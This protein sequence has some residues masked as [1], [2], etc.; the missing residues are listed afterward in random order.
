MKKIFRNLMTGLA[1]TAAAACASDEEEISSILPKEKPA[2]QTVA[3]ECNI[4]SFGTALGT[5]AG[6]NEAVYGYYNE[7]KRSFSAGDTIGFFSKGGNLYPADS[8]WYDPLGG[9]FNFPMTHRSGATFGADEMEADI[10]KFDYR[11]IYWPYHKDM[12]SAKGIPV[13]DANGN[14]IDLMIAG[15]SGS[16]SLNLKHAFSVI[17]LFRGNGFDAPKLPE[18]MPEGIPEKAQA[19]EGYIQVKMATPIQN[20]KMYPQTPKYNEKEMGSNDYSL[21]LFEFL[22]PDPDDGQDW[23]VFDG[24]K[25][26]NEKEYGI[27]L[28]TLDNSVAFYKNYMNWTTD[29]AGSSNRRNKESSQIK[30]ISL[31][32]NDGNWR[33]ITDIQM[34]E[35]D[36]VDKN[37]EDWKTDNKRLY[38]GI[39]YPLTVEMNNLGAQVFPARVMTWDSQ[40]ITETRPNG[41]NKDQFLEDF[42]P[43]YNTLNGVRASGTIGTELDEAI[44]TFNKGG[45]GTVTKQTREDAPGTTVSCTVMMFLSE[46]IEI[47]NSSYAELAYLMPQIYEGDIFEGNGHTISGISFVKNADN[48]KGEPRT[49]VK[50][51]KGTIRNLK[52]EDFDV[53]YSPDAPNEEPTG[54]FCA[55]LAATGSLLR[56]EAHNVDFSY[57]GPVGAIAGT[58]EKG[59]TIAN[60]E[61]S[62]VISGTAVN[63]GAKYIWYNGPEDMDPDKIVAN[64]INISFIDTYSGK[65]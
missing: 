45:Y 9:F 51:V 35:H 42:I 30:S 1:V 53:E 4:E 25:R 29:G 3:I 23:S 20:M 61:V 24:F 12:Y 63:Q 33:T 11:F 65:N 7:A 50:E 16:R 52:I 44:E 22:P 36:N 27:L 10:S 41:I 59:A 39:C 54:I 17:H 18:V 21:T 19:D 8:V 14:T 48:V 62:G 15:S 55:R 43:A 38:G 6:T 32:D 56:C 5:R 49:F 26:I 57:R 37:P 60:C 31:W 47:D 34:A 2:G 58:V 46:D 28:P 64:R 40:N 13:R